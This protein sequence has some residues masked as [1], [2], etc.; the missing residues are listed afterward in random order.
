MKLRTD[1][2]TEPISKWRHAPQKNRRAGLESSV[3]LRQRIGLYD[4]R[5]LAFGLNIPGASSTPAVPENVTAISYGLRQI[6][7]SCDASPNATHYRFFTLANLEQ[8]EPVFAGNSPT[9]SLVISDFEAGQPYQVFVSAANSAGESDLSEP[10]EVTPQALAAAA[11]GQFDGTTK[12][13]AERPGWAALF[14]CTQRKSAVRSIALVKFWIESGRFRY[15]H[16][17][18]EMPDFSDVP[19]LSG[20][21]PCD[22]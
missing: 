18:S 10:A 22:V 19:S 3:R 16:P 11:L 6:L 1:A 2:T 8:P 20:K 17:V 13:Q 12:Q 7:A 14:F 21:H 4:P 15:T 5:W 9:Q